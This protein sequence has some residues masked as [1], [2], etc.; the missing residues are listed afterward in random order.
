MSLTS[1]EKAAHPS[2]AAD[3]ATRP[4]RAGTGRAGAGRTILIVDDERIF[5][6]VLSLAL[7]RVGYQVACAY[8]TKQAWEMLKNLRPDLMILDV[9]MPDGDGLALLRTARHAPEWKK[10]PVVVLSGVS[11][12]HRIKEAQALAAR[13]YVLK[14]TCGVSDLLKR[15]QK[16]LPLPQQPAGE[17]AADMVAA[18]EVAAAAR[19]TVAQ[20]GRKQAAMAASGR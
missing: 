7:Q 20:T 14:G 8:D 1:G 4:A 18:P 9:S 17:D 15:V 12:W 11:Q 13:E 16:H 2:A 10:L 6:D 5:C 19:P 3:S